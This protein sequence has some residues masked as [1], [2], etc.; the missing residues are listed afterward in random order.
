[1]DASHWDDGPD[2]ALEV[3]AAAAECRTVGD[4][5]SHL[6][7]ALADAL[8]AD[9][10]IYHQ[11]V[12]A[13]PGS[14]YEDVLVSPQDGDLVG[15]LADFVSVAGD[16]PLLRHLDGPAPAPVFSLRELVSAR[17]WHENPVYRECFRSLG[18]EDHLAAVLGARDGVLHGV[19]LTRSARPF[20]GHDRLLVTVL[21]RH[22]RAALRRCLARAESYEA[23]EIAPRAHLAAHSGPAFP[24]RTTGARLTPREREVLALVA[25][26]LD[27]QRVAR[28]LQITRRTV[29]KHLENAFATLGARNRVEAVLLSREADVPLEPTGCAPDDARAR[30]AR[31]R[32]R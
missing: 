17:S 32:R 4:V 7:P 29:D 20:D 30:P 8:H 26:G 5:R 15:P 31:P 1:M 27:N 22:L 13:T 16:S 2:A 18:V 6:L 19:S 14:S 3:A 21:G 24:A 11:C 23:I 28:R 9:Q 12:P 10:V 25:C